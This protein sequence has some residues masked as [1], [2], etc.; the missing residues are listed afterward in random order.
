MQAED[1]GDLIS[2]KTL[3]YVYLCVCVCVCVYEYMNQS[4]Q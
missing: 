4:N 2:G 1:Q 3:I